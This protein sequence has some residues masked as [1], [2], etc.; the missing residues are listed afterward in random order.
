MA[1]A[2]DVRTLALTLPRT[3]EA[4]VRDQVKF[5][6]GRLVY[7][8]LS[9]DEQSMGFAFPREERVELI[10]SEPERYFMP[11]PSDERYNWVRVW[12]A[13]LDEDELTELVVG[14]WAMVVPKRLSADR[15]AQL[16]ARTVRRDEPGAP[17]NEDGAADD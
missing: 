17:V 7:V 13:P 10:A 11:V 15:L 5:R 6:V 4:L 1:T 14:A 8:A 3:E 16:G 2:Q 12:L 9:R